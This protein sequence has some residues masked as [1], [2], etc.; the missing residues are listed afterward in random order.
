MDDIND[1]FDFSKNFERKTVPRGC[2]SGTVATT[3]VDADDSKLFGKREYVGTEYAK[4]V[5]E[6][7]CLK[8]E[9][10]DLL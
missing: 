6:A 5:A 10:V 1:F 3:V 4:S 8:L 9:Q 2:V 7:E